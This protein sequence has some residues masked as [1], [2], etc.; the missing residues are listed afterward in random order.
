MSLP[1]ARTESFLWLAQ[2]ISAMVLAVCVTVHI[3]T[4][5]IAVQGGL[6]AAEIISRVGGSRLWLGFY[7]VFVTAVAIHAPIGLKSVLREMT[8]LPMRRIELLVGL[9]A[10]VIAALGLRAAFGLYGLGGQ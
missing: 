8:A 3:A 2:R 9:F 1:S 6:S 7:L 5:I 4:M 10:I